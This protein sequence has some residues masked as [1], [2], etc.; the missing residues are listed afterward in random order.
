MPAMADSWFILFCLMTFFY[1]I[2]PDDIFS[3]GIVAI[4]FS[5][6]SY[7]F[8]IIWIVAF[9]PP[10]IVAVGS[11]LSVL[12]SVLL[13]VQRYPALKSLSDDAADF[14][15][16]S[17][18]IR[19]GSNLLTLNYSDNWMLDNV[20]SYIAGERNIILL[21]NYEAKQSHFP[22][23]WKE[24]RSPESTGLISGGKNRPCLDLQKYKAATGLNIDYLLVMKR[25]QEL[26]DSCTVL[27]D[28]QLKAAY[29]EVFVT[30]NQKG[31]LYERIIGK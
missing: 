12:A 23:M 16:C 28:Q 21:D 13:L 9:C 18:H 4:R 7:L 19:E 5:L 11:V 17:E 29:R 1:F 14:S 3:G 20:S 24:N 25:P 10:R 15:T 26:N 22:I 6:M 31:V 30:P 2:L 8:L 27:V